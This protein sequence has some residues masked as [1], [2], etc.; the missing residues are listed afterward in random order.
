MDNISFKEGLVYFLPS[1]VL[2]NC[3]SPV[4]NG[5]LEVFRNAGSFL[6]FIYFFF[7]ENIR[8]NKAGCILSVGKI[9]SNYTFKCNI[10]ISLVL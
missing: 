1:A 7:L 10:K 4:Q 5:K 2:E 6:I 8:I 3:Y 9:M